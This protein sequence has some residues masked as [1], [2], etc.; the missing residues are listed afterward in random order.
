METKPDTP[1]IQLARK[2][3]IDRVQPREGWII[4]GVRKSSNIQLIDKTTAGLQLHVIKSGAEGI[5]PGQDVW[6]KDGGTRHVMPDVQGPEETY[7]LVD[8]GHVVCTIDP[9]QKEPTKDN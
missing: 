6:L 8:A 7:A 9:P 5:Q 4:I 3:D 2:V 1:I